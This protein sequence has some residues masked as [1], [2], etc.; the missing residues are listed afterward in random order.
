MKQ[1]TYVIAALLGASAAKMRKPSSTSLFAS[2]MAENSD[3]VA[4]ITYGD[5]ETIKV[6]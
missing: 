2:G 1:S 4:E 5:N 3:I 6:S